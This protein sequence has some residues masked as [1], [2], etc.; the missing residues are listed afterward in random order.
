MS[1]GGVIDFYSRQYMPVS[2]KNFLLVVCN[3]ASYKNLQ[4]TFLPNPFGSE[5]AGTRQVLCLCIQRRN[6]LPYIFILVYFMISA[7]KKSLISA[8][9]RQLDEVQELVCTDRQC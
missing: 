2:E 8:I 9:E 4:K 7:E 1:T 5:K 6:I 3:F